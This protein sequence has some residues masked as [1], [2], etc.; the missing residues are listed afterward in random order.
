MFFAISN[1]IATIHFLRLVF[2]LRVH[3]NIVDVQLHVQ[4]ALVDINAGTS[5]QNGSVSHP[6]VNSLDGDRGGST[7]GS[8]IVRVLLL[9]RQA[10]PQIAGRDEQNVGLVLHLDG[11]N[12]LSLCIVFSFRH[13]EGKYRMK[14]LHYLKPNSIVSS[15][16]LRTYMGSI[17]RSGK[18]YTLSIWLSRKILPHTNYYLVSERYL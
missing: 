18:D 6:G 17:F 15:L 5:G 3:E 1:E 16:N 12:F 13:S 2:N 7:G 10:Q 11:N 9:G 8:T 4:D 14:S